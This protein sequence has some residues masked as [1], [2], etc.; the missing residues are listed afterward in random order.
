MYAKRWVSKRTGKSGYSP[1][2]ENEWDEKLCKKG[3]IKCSECSDRVYRK[4][5]SDDIYKHLSKNAAENDVIGVY[6]MLKYETTNFVVIDFDDENWQQDVTTIRRSCNTIGVPVYVERSRS[7]KGAHCWFFFSEPIQAKLARR[8]ASSVISYSMNHNHKIKF[9]SYDR[10]LLN[11]DNM[12][13][14]GFGNLIAL[15]LQGFS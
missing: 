7:G 6:P 13:D 4:L 14:G 5:T 12:P 11:Q 9:E 2:C 8:F 15:P 3:R 10:L 1:V